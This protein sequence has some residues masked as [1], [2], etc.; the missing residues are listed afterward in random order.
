MCILGKFDCNFTAFSSSPSSELPYITASPVSSDGPEM[1]R[2]IERVRA[3]SA[4]RFAELAI[5]H[6]VF[7]LHVLYLVRGAFLI[8]NIAGRI[9]RGLWGQLLHGYFLRP[10]RDG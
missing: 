5:H 10:F 2:L 7:F 4:K 6:C 1:I 9:F 8:R 3:L